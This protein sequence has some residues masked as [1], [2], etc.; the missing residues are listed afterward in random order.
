MT[1]KVGLAI[2]V[3]ATL[4]LAAGGFTMWLRHDETVLESDVDPR[5][6]VRLDLAPL[7]PW[8]E[9]AADLAAFFPAADRHETE[10]RILSGLRPELARRLG[11]Q[12][13]AEENAIHLHHVFHETHRLGTVVVRRVKGEYGAI[14]LVLAVDST[15][16]IRGLRLQRQ[17]EPEALAAA[18]TSETW[19]AAFGG[20]T[21]R[22]E[23]QAG[24]DLPDVPSNALVSTRA[25][26]QGVRELLI[27]LDVA[28]DPRAIRQSPVSPA[29]HRHP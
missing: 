27:L 23:L 11:R 24:R 14:E 13:S 28:T 19:L 7:C 21:V 6:A 3:S 10:I 4:L 25:V 20:K 17:R 26:T 5:R 15:G 9:P 1:R 29:E 16:A 2:G 22:D 8:R 12:A 18:L